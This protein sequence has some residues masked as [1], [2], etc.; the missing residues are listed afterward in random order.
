VNKR[1]RV[2]AA[3]EGEP[4]D[5]VPLSLWRH[6]HKQDQTPTGLASATLAFYHRYDFDLI[7]LTPSSFYAIEDWGAQIVLSKDD[8]QPPHVKKPVIKKPE[9]WRNLATLSATEGSYGQTLEAVALV[10]DQLE[11]EDVTV[12]MTIFSPLTLAYKLAGEMLFDH[13]EHHPTD[14]Q[15]GLATIAETTSRFAGSVLEN[16]AD[17]IFFASQLS[18][19]DL[20]TE[21]MCQEFVVRYDLIAL[22]RVKLHP[23]PLVVHLHG[24]NIYFNTVN[25]YPAHAVSWHNHDTSPSLAEALTLTDKTLV[26]GLDP[27]LLEQGR[28]EEVA[29]QVTAA[30]AE[31]GGQRLILA[32]SCVIS[33]N[34]PEE[35]LEA[36]VNV[37]RSLSGYS[38]S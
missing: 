20:L 21:E 23:A 24:E 37:D 38:E 9:D 28:P 11:E 36:V 4:V 16:G 26:A 27:N 15:I 2:Y 30:I 12:L 25:Q 35:T 6:F 7:K 13:L 32:P 10:M 1:E 17:G 29:A 5:R 22:E 34:T 14:V 19:S 18:R 33:P 8:A 3:L 31:T